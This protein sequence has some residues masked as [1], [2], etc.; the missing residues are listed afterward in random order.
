MQMR[1]LTNYYLTMLNQ[2]LIHQKPIVTH[3]PNKYIEWSKNIGSNKY[4]IKEMYKVHKQ[5]KN[6]KTIQ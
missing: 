5:N 1:Q 3:T 6:T 2:I 4:L